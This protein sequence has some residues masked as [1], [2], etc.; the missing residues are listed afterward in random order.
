MILDRVTFKLGK[1]YCGRR[2]ITDPIRHGVMIANA[3]LEQNQPSGV[4]SIEMHVPLTS[5]YGN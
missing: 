3:D 2:L 4:G 5:K 1:I